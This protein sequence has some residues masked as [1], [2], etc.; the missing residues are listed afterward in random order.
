MDVLSEDTTL[1]DDFKSVQPSMSIDPSTLPFLPFKDT[2]TSSTTP[3]SNWHHM[4]WLETAFTEKPTVVVPTPAHFPV[5]S[6]SHQYITPDL[7]Q[8]HVIIQQHIFESTLANWG[9]EGTYSL[10]SGFNQESIHLQNPE[11]EIYIILESEVS[12][13]LQDALAEL[14][15]PFTGIIIAN[16]PGTHSS[17]ATSEE[18]T[19]GVESLQGKPQ[20]NGGG[21]DTDMDDH[22]AGNERGGGNGGSHGGNSGGSLQGGGN[23]DGYGG[24]E[25]GGKGNSNS[26]GGNDDSRDGG[27][28]GSNGL[29]DSKADKGSDSNQRRGPLHIPFKSHLVSKDQK[30]KFEI[31]GNIKVTVTNENVDADTWPGPLV[32]VDMRRLQ[33]AFKSSTDKYSLDLCQVLITASSS[34]LNVVDWSPNVV[35]AEDSN[36]VREERNLTGTASM[37]L[38]MNPSLRIDGNVGAIK[39]SEQEQQ[40][41]IISSY[42]DIEDGEGILWNYKRNLKGGFRAVKI[43]NFNPKPTISFGLDDTPLVDLPKLKIQIII[44]WSCEKEFLSSLRRKSHNDAGTLPANMNFLHQVTMVVDLK[45]YQGMAAA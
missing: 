3:T 25:P 21:K 12:D 20:D 8:L 9:Y 1:W 4:N 22:S 43:E 24:G 14:A 32:E 39:G 29:D 35:H 2:A 10:H 11:Q 23:G 16:I 34:C 37:T 42:S 19:E 44:F 18:S 31:Y 30:E 15:L 36:K 28:P 33:A 40:P 5:E 17:W 13:G 26:D 38:S 41:W 27:G 7:A 45:K 6:F